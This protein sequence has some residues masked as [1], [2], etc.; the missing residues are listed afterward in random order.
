M[1][2]KIKKRNELHKKT[3]QKRRRKKKPPETH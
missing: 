2:K 3:K 1:G